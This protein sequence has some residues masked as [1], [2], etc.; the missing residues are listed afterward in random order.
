MEFVEMRD[1]L[2]EHF[3]KMTEDCTHLF[4]VQV[5]KDEMWNAYLNSFP[6]GSNP[7]FRERTWHDCSCCRGFIK[8]VGNVVT[9]KNGVLSTIWDFTCKDF[10]YD[11]V[12]K[13]MVRTP[14]SFSSVG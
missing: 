12:L 14:R 13:N 7:M 5:D 4:A 6:A 8:S 3:N 10:V 9:I 1:M 2:I 11:T